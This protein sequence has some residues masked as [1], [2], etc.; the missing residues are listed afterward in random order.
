[1]L[2]GRIYFTTLPKLVKKEEREREKYKNVLTKPNKETMYL[3]NEK[4]R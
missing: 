4:I 2:K 1:M 3:M